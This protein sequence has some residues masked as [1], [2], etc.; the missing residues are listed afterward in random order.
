MLRAANPYNDIL[1]S[2]TAF[3]HVVS[4]LSKDDSVNNDVLQNIRVR[5]GDFAKSASNEGFTLQLSHKYIDGHGL[6]Y[7]V[8]K[9][10]ISEKARLNESSG[11]CTGLVNGF[12]YW[13][14]WRRSISTKRAN[15]RT[16]TQIFSEEVIKAF[17]EL[18]DKNIGVVVSLGENFFESLDRVWGNSIALIP[19]PTDEL[20]RMS[21]APKCDWKKTLVEK[22][23]KTIRILKRRNLLQTRFDSVVIS[24]IGDLSG[25]P[26]LPNESGLSLLY[27]AT[28][29]DKECANL[30]LW[31][32]LDMQYLLIC[33]DSNH[34]ALQKKEVIGEVWESLI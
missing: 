12:P 3:V 18:Q 7:L 32:H 23:E 1:E 8:N 10:G 30:I 34:W 16:F 11:S 2:S 13:A 22:A 28:P 27:G 31:S 24:S 29:I 20:L 19:F 15:E 17:T 21:Q 25:S 26:Y 33:A 14:V 9:L 5:G 4:H 6:V